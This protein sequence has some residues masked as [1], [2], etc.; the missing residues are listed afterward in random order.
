MDNFLLQHPHAQPTVIM[1]ND[2]HQDNLESLIEPD[3]DF[4]N[5]I[6]ELTGLVVLHRNHNRLDHLHRLTLRLHLCR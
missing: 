5:S 1:V 2:V 3:P 4:D 6:E